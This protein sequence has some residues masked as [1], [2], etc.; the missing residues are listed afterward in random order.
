MP[1]V[2]SPLNDRLSAGYDNGKLVLTVP[3][4]VKDLDPPASGNPL[5][6]WQ[7]FVSAFSAPGIPRE[8][9]RIVAQGRK[10][11]SRGYEVDPFPPTDATVYVTFREEPEISAIPGVVVESGSTYEQGETDFEA[12]EMAK[13]FARRKPIVVTYESKWAVGPQFRPQSARVP[14][15]VGKTF[16]RYTIPFLGFDPGELSEEFVPCTNARP[17]R[18]K[19]ADKPYKQDEAMCISIVGRNAGTG[20]EGVFDFAIDRRTRFHQV[21]RW[22]N[23]ENGQYPELKPEDLAKNNGIRDCIVQFRADFNRL[24]IPK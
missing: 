9:T 16:R 10:L 13:P 12:S 6:E 19:G 8:G 2:E 17:W 18:P 4:F 7:R 3:F 15:L 20:W 22:V 24:P 1:T 21:A 14:V 11:Y 23:P 5:D